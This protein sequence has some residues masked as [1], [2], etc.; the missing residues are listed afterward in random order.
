MRFFCC[1]LLLLTSFISK[2]QSQELNRSDF[3]LGLTGGAS[4][5]VMR[6]DAK[7]KEGNQI[8]V[9]VLAGIESSYVIKNKL[10]LNSGL[11]F[12]YKSTQQNIDYYYF[13][14]ST[15]SVATDRLKIVRTFDYLTIPFLLK[16]FFNL[17]GKKLTCFVEAGGYISFLLNQ[18]SYHYS[19]NVL[20]VTYDEVNDFGKTDSG[21]SLALGSKFQI[22]KG[23][24]SEVRIL[25]NYG[26][27]NIHGIDSKSIIKVNSTYITMSVF[28][29]IH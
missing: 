26:L 22:T 1:I 13:N 21:I 6:G 24:F 5:T 9:G 2:A 7:V 14:E 19:G 17:S 3:Q 29:K 28:K 27:K 23:L 25:N 10:A 8:G 15:Q 11:L 18:T 20:N 12:D 16:Y 4:F